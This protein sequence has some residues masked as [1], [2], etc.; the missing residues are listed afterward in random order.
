MSAAQLLEVVDFDSSWAS[1]NPHGKQPDAIEWN[2]QPLLLATYQQL[3][4]KD[5]A[6]QG[7]REDHPRT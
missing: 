6:E 5:E 7:Q 1:R 4:P 2:A 3:R